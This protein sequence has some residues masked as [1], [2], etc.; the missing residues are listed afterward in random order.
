MAERGAERE[1]AQGAVQTATWC[2][3]ERRWQRCAR[4]GW[5]EASESRAEGPRNTPL[6]LDW[7]M[8][9][10][11][12][13]LRKPRKGNGYGGQSGGGGYRAQLARTGTALESWISTATQGW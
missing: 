3:R 5:R 4:D 7:R 12:C 11:V 2:D 10:L 13:V 6:Q 8:V 1:T 9:A